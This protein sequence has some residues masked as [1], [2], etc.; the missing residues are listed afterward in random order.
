[1]TPSVNTN[2]TVQAHCSK[3]ETQGTTGP[4]HPVLLASHRQD[5]SKTSKSF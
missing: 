5:L 4:E 1:M 3:P 2:K